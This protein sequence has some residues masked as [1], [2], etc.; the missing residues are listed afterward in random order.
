MCVRGG[1]CVM[2]VQCVGSLC[3]LGTGGSGKE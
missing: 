2:R 1:E 3:V